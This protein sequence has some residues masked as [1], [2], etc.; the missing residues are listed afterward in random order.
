MACLMLLRSSSLNVRLCAATVLNNMCLSL[1]SQHLAE[2]YV[3][4]ALEYCKKEMGVFT[5]YACGTGGVDE[6]GFENDGNEADRRDRQRKTKRLS[7][8]NGNGNTTK[9]PKI[10]LF[11]GYCLLMSQLVKQLPNKHREIVSLT[12]ANITAVFEFGVGL[13]LQDIR[14][15]P[16]SSGRRFICALIRCG[17]LLITSCVGLGYKPY[18]RNRL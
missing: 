17:C 4:D 9:V 3:S 6:D 11:H 12:D 13:L 14:I 8:T 5:A 7:N 15:V 1:P 18:F 10:H 2:V 16:T